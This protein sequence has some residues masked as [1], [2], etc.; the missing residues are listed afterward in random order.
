[1]AAT[2]Q[3]ATPATSGAARASLLSSIALALVSAVLLDFCFPVAGPLPLWRTP[4]SWIALVPLLYA[5]LSEKNAAHPRYPRNSAV[6]GWFF[7][8]LFY[9]LNCYWIYQTMRFYGHVPPIGSAGILFLFSAG[10]GGYG[11]LFGFLTAYFRRRFGLL[12]ALA[13]APFLWSALD[14]LASRFTSVPWDQLGYAQVDNFWLSRLAPVAGVYGIT[15]VLMAGNALFA[16]AL[17]QKP[18][19]IL[20]GLIGLLFAA[21]LQL[22]SWIRPAPAPTSATAVLLQDNLSV[23]ED[24]SWPGSQWNENIALFLRASQQSCT[25]YFTGLPEPDATTPTP[26]CSTTPISLIAWPEAPSPF[27]GWDPRF[28]QTMA[29]LTTA[30][31]A[32][33]ISGNISADERITEDGQAIFDEYNSATVFAPSGQQIG[34]YDKIHLVPFGEFIPYRNVFFFA[35]HLT[36]N[37]GD[38]ARGKARKVFP[39]DDGHHRFGIFICYEAVFADE[40]RHFAANGAEVLV[41]ISDDGWY[42]DTSAPWQHLNM[43]RMRAI[44]NRRWLLRDTNTGVTVAIDPY[45][46][47]TQSAPRHVFTSLAVRYGYRSDVTFYSAHGDVFALICGLVVFAAIAGARLRKQSPAA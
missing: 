26:A 25:P 23:D 5:F 41:N 38:F 15:V 2:L 30:T 45:G 43:A 16:A 31:H 32:T 17:L 14:L 6:A 39:I 24:N 18:R 47:I 7:G 12:F 27:R 21:A 8:L 46:R 1:V 4:L 34:R 3:S 37:V 22:G 29:A 28:T 11:A 42:G 40:V 33:A 9:I 35:K 19:R 44:E 36:Q 20:F 10:L 13:L